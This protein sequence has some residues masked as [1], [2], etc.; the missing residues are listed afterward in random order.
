MFDDF[1]LPIGVFTG[2]RLG[3][4]PAEYLRR[5]AAS[6]FGMLSDREVEVIR[7][8]LEQRPEGDDE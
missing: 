4:V 6:H 8:H 7:A 5:L 2:Y 3:D 1:E